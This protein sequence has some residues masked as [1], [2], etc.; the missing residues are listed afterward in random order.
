MALVGL[1]DQA[2]A[3]AGFTQLIPG[4]RYATAAEVA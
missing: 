3:K 1:P 2:T 4:A